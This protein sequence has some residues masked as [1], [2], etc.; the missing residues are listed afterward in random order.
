MCIFS[1]VLRKLE[2][3]SPDGVALNRIIAIDVNKV[4]SCVLSF[5]WTLILFVKLRMEFK[6]SFGIF[7]GYSY[8]IFQNP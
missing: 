8:S 7:E 4:L 6:R 1:E 2:G 5:V 3:Y